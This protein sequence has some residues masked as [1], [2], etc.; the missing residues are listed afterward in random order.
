MNIAFLDSWIQSNAEGS[1]TAVSIN[2]LEQA[3]ELRGHQVT[4]IAPLKR[5]PRNLTLRRLLFNAQLP[6]LLRR[7]HYDLIVGFDIDGFLWSLQERTTPYVVF[8]KGVIAEELQ[9]EHGLTRLLFQMLA[10]LEGH[11]ARRADLV[12]TDS[13]YGRDAIAKHYGVTHERLGVLPIGTDLAYWQR[14]SE[15]EPRTTDGFTILCVARQYPRKHIADLIRAV[16]IIQHSIPQVR[17][18]LVGDG[19]EHAALRRLTAALQLH[20]AVHFAGAI[21]DDALA[22]AYRH[23]DIFCLPSVQENFGVV[24]IEAM[25]NRLPIVAT[26]AAAIPEVV[27]DRVVGYL[28]PPG[29]IEALAQVLVILLRSP[30]QRYIFGEN[31]YQHVQRFNWPQIA[32]MFLEQVTPLLHKDYHSKSEGDCLPTFEV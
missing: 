5:W 22:Q 7:V 26:T 30:N 1:G 24:F 27:P 17:V 28:V 29:N 20:K 21:S 32:D 16:P 2:G 13:M 9:H 14:A 6:M 8:V 11:N 10:H 18:V 15:R 4:R 23:A 25:A 19:P 3:L 31:S 12:L